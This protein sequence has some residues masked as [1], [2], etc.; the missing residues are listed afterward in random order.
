MSTE[1][2]KEYPKYPTFNPI[3]RQNG[4]NT[5][6][7]LN[8]KNVVYEIIYKPNE[9]IDWKKKKLDELKKYNF[10]WGDDEEYSGKEFRIFGKKFVKRNKYTCKI[11]YNNKEYELKEYF[12]EIDN[13]YQDKN[14]IKL[15]FIIIIDIIDMSEMFYGC[16]HLISFSEYSKDKIY[17]HINYSKDI[18]SESNYYS[19]LSEED[20]F[21]SFYNSNGKQLPFYND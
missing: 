10:L 1:K 17:Q 6:H 21:N 11:I 7:I 2:E 8:K 15:K 19:S 4:N 13:N 16:Y 9:N 5:S 14:I 3:S 18:I 12:K 20:K